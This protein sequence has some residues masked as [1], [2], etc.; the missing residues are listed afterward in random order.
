[1]ATSG[2]SLEE[3]HEQ[4]FSDIR[5]LVRETNEKVGQLHELSPA[6]KQ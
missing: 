6:V 4:L 2:P 1:M 3:R 5:P